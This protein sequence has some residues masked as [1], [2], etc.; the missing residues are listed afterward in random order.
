MEVQSRPAPVWDEFQRLPGKSRWPAYF[1]AG[2]PGRI[3]GRCPSARLPAGS[4]VTAGSFLFFGLQRVQ[5]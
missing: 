5:A 4:N 1:P 3:L 2:L